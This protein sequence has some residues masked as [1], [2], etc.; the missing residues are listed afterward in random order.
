MNPVD[1]RI[2]YLPTRVEGLARLASNLWW[3][4]SPDARALFAAVDERL[5]HATRHNPVVTLRQAD[6]ARLA[7]C[8]SDS[9]FLRRYDEVMAAFQ[10]ALADPNTWYARHHG[11]LGDRPIAYFC[12]EFGLHASVPIY[13]GGLGVLAG[14]H[15][16]SASD[17]GVPLV[18]VGLFYR[19]G[20]FDQKVNLE[21]WQVDSDEVYD[22]AV[23]P[24]EPVAGPNGEAWVTVVG[25]LGRPVHVRAWRMMAGRVPLILLDTDLPE[26]HPDDRG[27]MNKLYAGGPAMRIRQ[28][29]ILGVGG[30]RV[31]RAL[32]IA[33]A[34]WHAN[35][36]HAAFMFVER[37]R[38]LVAQ[39]IAVDE[40]V[41]QVRATSV[42]TTHTP[43]PAGHDFFPLAQL[44][45]VAGPVWEELG[46]SREAFFDVGSLPGDKD[47]FHMTAVAIRLASRVNG[48][49]RRHGQVSRNLWKNL[50]PDRPAETVPI[51]HVTNGVHLATWMAGPIQSL[52]A[53]HLG[54]DWQ[55]RFNDDP[56]LWDQVL[57]LDH[58]RL[59][60]AHRRLKQLL[61]NHIREDARHRFA[62]QLKEAAA[63]V[64]AGT[65]LDPEV[66]T[67]G[68]ARRFATYKRASLIFRDIERLRRLCTNPYRPVQVI[69]A[70]K[71][72]PEDTPGKEVL[73]EVYRWTR[74]PRFE[75]RIAFLEDYDMHLAHLLVQG[76]DLWLN[77]P[78]VPHEASGTSGM[79]AALNGV[80]QLSTLD[81][82]WQEGYDGLGGWAVPPAAEG[83]E[84]D[85]LDADHCYRIFEE[86]VVP[87][88]YTRD[89]KGI[90]LGWAERMR[91]ALRLG[92]RRFTAHR[93]VADYVQEYYAPAIRCDPSGDAPPTA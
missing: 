24:L 3:S 28:E 31:L 29:W 9:G 41:R 33:P 83:A 92:G 13:S 49:S 58:E 71:A 73:Q 76:V 88:F 55:R 16:K 27:L 32:G 60:I 2:P 44:E 72:H 47:N 63:V 86:Q 15:V 19:Y 26:N 69:F 4:W 56:S 37:V 40:A 84:S 87:L 6:P 52:L 11:E 18:A 91:H 7:A 75:G 38:E 81:G 1:Q 36:G 35:E 90:P 64:G 39:G 59:W 70:G 34:A 51:G 77:L 25:T 74:D 43:V 54:A 50:W 68:F 82:W 30:V 53:N 42:F 10:K 67:I 20:Y 61:V 78:R 8:A 66:L 48:V 65:L 93:M 46:V 80:P 85:D 12:A 22:V 62:G 89:S 14:D 45:A 21:G 23:T 79:K 17:L 5:W 57:S